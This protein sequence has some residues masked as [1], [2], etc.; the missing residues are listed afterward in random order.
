M[1]SLPHQAAAVAQ[2]AAVSDQHRVSCPSQL[3]PLCC[4]HALLHRPAVVAIIVAVVEPINALIYPV[5]SCI[6]AAVVIIIYHIYTAIA[7]A[8][9][10]DSCCVH[11]SK[12]STVLHQAVATAH[13]SYA[14]MPH[15]LMC[16]QC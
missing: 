10:L 15:Q 8:S 12:E 4:A 1:V 6:A 5:A 7:A 2:A 11:H 9:V 3:L 13:C 16:V 14:A